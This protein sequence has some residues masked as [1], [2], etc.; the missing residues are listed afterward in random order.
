L[1]TTLRILANWLLL[2]LSTGE[3]DADKQRLL[4]QLSLLDAS[5][6]GGLAAY[7]N[8]AKQLLADSKEGEQINIKPTVSQVLQ[9]HL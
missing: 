8:N 1:V 3:A 4:Q 7:I 5:Y 6:H 9:L 2:L